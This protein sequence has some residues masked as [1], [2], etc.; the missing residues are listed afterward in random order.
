MDKLKKDRK[1]R[2]PKLSNKTEP[3]TE[4]YYTSF[5][6]SDGKPKRK[7]FSKDLEESQ[8][9]YHRWVIENYDKSAEIITSKKTQSKNNFPQSLPVIANAYIQ[10]ERER[11]RPDGAKRIRGTI[12]IRV[13]DDNPRHVINILK[14]SKSRCRVSGRIRGTAGT[15][16]PLCAGDRCPHNVPAC[17]LEIN[18]V[19]NCRST[20]DP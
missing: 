1:R 16:D 14:W 6:D 12:S 15:G 17:N 20:S 13:F 10:H 18:R 4:R 9:M 3:G 19:I 7:R 2:I 8:L 5:R 11:V